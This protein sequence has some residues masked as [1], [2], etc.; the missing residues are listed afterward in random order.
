MRIRAHEPHVALKTILFATDF[1][2]A[3]G[4]AWPFAVALR[5][6]YGAHLFIA[7]VIPEEAYIHA[8]PESLHRV[9]KEAS[10]YATEALDQLA[11][12]IKRRGGICTPVLEK[13]NV[14]HTLAQLVLQLQV[15]LAIIGTGSRGGL[16]K[17]LLGSVA[18]AFIRDA[19]CPVLTVGPHV[20]SEQAEGIQTIICATDFSDESFRAARTAI[21]LADEYEARIIVLH[22]VEKNAVSS[23]LELKQKLEQ[24]FCEF[25][26]NTLAP[27]KPQVI[28]QHGDPADCILRISSELSASMIAMGVRGSGSLGRIASHF[29]SVAHDVVCGAR[30]P[31]VSAGAP[32]TALER[33]VREPELTSKGRPEGTVEPLCRVP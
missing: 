17:V 31:V 29:G 30:C 3:S 16:Q 19:G 21:A 5:H 25:L 28:V 8:R 13:G 27:R 18:E 23:G 9:L 32:V 11:R 2:V 10:S 7:H 12:A 6:R 33:T 1:D 26:E 4:R 20:S 14:P 24:R 22:V 15:D